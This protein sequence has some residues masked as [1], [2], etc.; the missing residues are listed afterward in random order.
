MVRNRAVNVVP[1]RQPRKRA[2][3]QRMIDAARQIFERD[4]YGKAV[5]VDIAVAAGVSRATFYLHFQ[6]KSDVFLAVLD[7]HRDRRVNYWRSMS[8][9]L[10]D[11]TRDAIRLWLETAIR[12]YENE[13]EL[14]LI[15]QE[16]VAIDRDVARYWRTLEK[17]AENELSD[18][19]S[20]FSAQE[21]RRQRL[22][23]L[24]LSIQLDYLLVIWIVQKQLH[25][26]REEILEVLTDSWTGTLKSQGHRLDSART[27]TKAN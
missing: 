18:Y 4:G 25:F 9:A 12:G 10:V 8:A 5:V 17:R 11:G 26:D 14:N 20:S 23:V 15:W 22:R 19:L 2:T 21:R 7:V 24:A 3:R 27:R 16:A 13:R 1:S 6:K